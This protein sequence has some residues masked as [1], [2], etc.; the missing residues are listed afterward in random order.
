M[1]RSPLAALLLTGCALA[2]GAAAQQAAGA[3][4]RCQQHPS[5]SI[6]TPDDGRLVAGVL[7]PAQGR[8]H[9]S[10]NVREQRSGGLD[11][12]RWG[13][14]RVVRAVLGG[15]AAYRRRSPHAPRVAVGDM[16]LRHGGDID[17][18]TTH[19]NGREIDLF[20]PRRDRDLR[21]PDTD[22]QVDL[23]LARSL[24][25]AMLHAGASRVLIGPDIDIATPRHVIRRPQYA[26]HMHVMF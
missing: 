4:P 3:A 18:H 9:V 16:S 10:W 8:D 7:F 2:L 19:E 23:E 20:F 1:R 25:E 5:R 11:R 6:G 13:D 15:L 22:A 24:V 12:T 26:E 17:G 14:C 21:E